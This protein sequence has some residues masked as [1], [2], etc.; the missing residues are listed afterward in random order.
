M[1]TRPTANSGFAPTQSW[2]SWGLPLNAPTVEAGIWQKVKL[3][4]KDFSVD[5]Y[6]NGT[7][8]DSFVF[9]D[10]GGYIGL[11]GDA[12]GS[13]GGRFDNIRVH[14]YSAIEP[15]INFGKAISIKE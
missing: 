6:I 7:L 9:T 8:Y 12:S 14:K 10:S 11:H 3:V 1:D 15:S 13:G 2:S 4:I 5:G